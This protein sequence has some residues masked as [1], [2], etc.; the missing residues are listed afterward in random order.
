MPVVK[1]ARPCCFI[2]LKHGWCARACRTP[3]LN[4]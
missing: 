1:C 3:V 2:N 4:S